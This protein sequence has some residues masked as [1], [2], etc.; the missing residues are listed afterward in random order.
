MKENKED[1]ARRLHQ[2]RRMGIQAKMLS[3][4]LGSLVIVLVITG[5][6]LLTQARKEIVRLTDKDISSQAQSIQL[7]S[8]AYF[9]SF[10]CAM[11]VFSNSPT[12]QKITREE[13][14]MGTAF[15]YQTSLL[16]NDLMRELKTGKDCLPEGTK[17]LFIATKTNSQVVKSDGS[18]TDSSFVVTDRVWWKDL[19]A[20]NGQPI[21]SAAY[22]DVSGG[23]VVTVAVPINH[24]GKMVGAVGANISL[25][26]V[27]S[28]MSKFRV[29]E[30]GFAVILDSGNQVI[31][32]PDQNLLL[33]D[34]NETDYNQEFKDQAN[35]HTDA[36]NCV[37]TEGNQE[38]HGASCY[39]PSIGWQVFGLMP[40]KEFNAEA[41]HFA[42][43]I[44]I[45]FLLIAIL[46]AV[47]MAVGVGRMVKPIRKLERVANDLAQGELDVE[48]DQRG[49]DEIGDLARSIAKIV[50]RLKTYIA[51]IDEV[52]GVLEQMGRRNMVFTLQYDY[53]GEFRKLKIAMEEIQRELSRAMYTIADSTEQVD[54]GA[55][56]MAGGAQALAQGATEQASTIQELA[57]AIQDLTNQTKQE[58]D[59]ATETSSQ[60]KR[61]GD[62]VI[63]S[64]Q[65]MGDMLAAMGKIS[66]QSE[67]IAKIV[68]AVEDIAFQ[69]NILALNAAVEAARA[70]SA[71][72]GFAVVADEV[73]NLA[74]KSS[75]AAKS[76]TD[77][78]QKTID[79]VQEGSSIADLT[80]ASLNEVA[81]EIGGVV[82]SVDH[83]AEVYHQEAEQLSQVATGVDQVSAVVQTNSA[84]AEESAATA[85]E[86]AAQVNT[87][88]EL[89]DSFQLDERYRK[90]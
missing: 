47:L 18:Y 38:F 59:K 67:E 60:T 90:L 65:Q 1:S 35:Q 88:K 80:A 87:M 57:A 24:G 63:T 71:G 5:I 21:V 30:T 53:V 8:E 52:S 36:A 23:I 83:I 31:Y 74:G 6:T 10:F 34:V 19:V 13:E 15:Q 84:T 25:D 45:C 51:Y 61:I 20:S 40:E 17:S 33:R 79:V 41:A 76:I 12:V 29:G 43:I 49:N 16:A 78:I 56:N 82:D 85:E 64:N 89:V 68:K 4:L 69:T 37:Y 3:T 58:V 39:I 62:K 32:H 26:H 55:G 9:H 66:T 44:T 81:Q 22:E 72:K 48:V 46:L 75:N 73:R 70:G 11:D 42:R 50:E 54:A 27:T 7:E 77:L 28:L 2:K 14:Q 86:L